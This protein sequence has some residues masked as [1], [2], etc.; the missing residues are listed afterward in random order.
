[1]HRSTNVSV[2]WCLQLVLVASASG[3]LSTNFG[4]F[5]FK[6]CCDSNVLQVFHFHFMKKIEEITLACQLK[7]SER[8][9]NFRSL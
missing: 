3:F 8:D 2:C 9:W 5:L 1:M 4:E 7:S 6:I